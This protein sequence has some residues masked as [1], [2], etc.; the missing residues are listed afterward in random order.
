MM[1]VAVR[2]SPS[3]EADV[4]KS[5]FLARVMLP[6]LPMRAHYDVSPDGQRFLIGAPLG[7]EALE[8]ANVVL[9]WAAEVKAK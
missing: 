1:S 8:G 4:P 5:L 2:T 3:F 9:N 6:G 7:S